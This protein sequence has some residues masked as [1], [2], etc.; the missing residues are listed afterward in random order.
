M[1]VEL[2]DALREKR[3]PMLITHRPDYTGLLTRIP[4][5]AVVLT[6]LTDPHTTTLATE[7]LGTDPS[8]R[9][10]AER[11]VRIASGNP[12]FATEIVRDLVERGVLQGQCG[13]YRSD[14]G[15]ADI[16]VPPT[17][18]ATIAARID[19]LTPSAKSVLYA[20]AVIGTRFRIELLGAV[21]QDDE[22]APAAIADLCA[23]ELVDQV[24]TAPTAE[25]AFRHPLVRAVAYESQL[26]AAR[27][28][29]HRRVAAAIEGAG[30]GSTG[31][32]AALIAGHLQSAGE[33]RAAFDW[34]MRAGG[35][36][37]TRDRLGAWSSWQRARA[38]ADELPEG[39]PER[40]ALQ[41]TVL[42]RLCSEV[43]KIGG[44]LEDAGFGQL[45]RLCSESGDYRSLAIGLAGMVMALTG[46][47]R[48]REAADLIPE[49]MTL[50][51][52]IRDPDVS[53]GL[54]LA[55][56]YAKSE[57]GELR[58]ALRLAQQVIDLAGGNLRKGG[59]LFGSPLTSATRMRGLYR[60]CLGVEGWRSDGDAAIT[61]ARE[62]DPTSRVSSLMYKYILSVPVGARRVDE[63]ARRETAEALEI[64][65]QAGDELTLTSAQVARGLV[66]STGTIP[67]GKAPNFSPRLAT[68]LFVAD[69]R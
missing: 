3:S 46:Q 36:L 42:T 28:D 61:M 43:W 32:K 2:A 45:R 65:E 12:F 16:A 54:L 34:H 39:N 58:E 40:A 27:S 57:V 9:P 19:R 5:T 8:V 18:Q 68:Q 35:W 66:L 56:T 63:L 14:D 60:L 67:A 25:F 13:Q 52:S 38:V 1:F 49:L 15:H 23:A 64:A 22:H 48:H 59:V 17:L 47:H 26:N 41:T 44:A 69:S 50:V 6:P 24:P 11:I 33:L 51:E 62:L 4:A 30:A 21:L 53:C 10:L 29:M 31:Q 55:V 37:L 20:G 7:L